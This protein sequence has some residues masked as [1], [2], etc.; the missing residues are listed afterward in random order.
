M[1]NKCVLVLGGITSI[2]LT[3]SVEAQN[4]PMNGGNELFSQH[5]SICHEV[6]N[7]TKQRHNSAEWREIV[8]RM[9]EHGADLTTAEQEQIIAYLTSCFGPQSDAPKLP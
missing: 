4:A 5:C 1:L 7:A 8:N 6:T 9:V 2:G 3:F